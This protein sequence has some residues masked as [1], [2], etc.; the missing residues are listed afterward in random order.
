MQTGKI[1]VIVGAMF[2][3]KT[4]ELI[5]RAKR[6]LIS[7]KQIQAFKSDKDDRYSLTDIVSHAGVTLQAIPV[8]CVTEMVIQ[9][10]P[11]TQVVCIDEAQ[12]FNGAIVDFCEDL[13]NRGI[14]VI[15]AGL[16]ADFMDRPFGPMPQLMVIADKIVHLSAVCP[17][18]HHKATRTVRLCD[19]V[20]ITNGMTI[21][22]GGAEQ[23][24]PRCRK[25]RL[26]VR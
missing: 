21:V 8:K 2:S 3:G 1:V 13:A 26:T 16:A 22:I 11:D 7:Q 23:Y 20:P 18:C 12:F 24:E 6:K 17:V 5:R 19:G 15:V 9:L 25:H 4:E 14:Y 10:K